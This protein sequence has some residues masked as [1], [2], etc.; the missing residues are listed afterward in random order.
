MEEAV[1]AT[2]GSKFGRDTHAIVDG[3]VRLVAQK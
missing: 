2:Y 3:I 1:V